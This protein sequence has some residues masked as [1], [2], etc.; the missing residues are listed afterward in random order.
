M[1]SLFDKGATVSEKQELYHHLLECIDCMREYVE[2]LQAT[3]L[4]TPRGTA[5]PFVGKA[6][7]MRPDTVKPIS[8]P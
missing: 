2:T 6:D 1:A 7:N 4:L 5:R 3:D 8:N